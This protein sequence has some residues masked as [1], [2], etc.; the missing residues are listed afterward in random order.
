MSGHCCQVEMGCEEIPNPCTCHCPPCAAA[1]MRD[2]PMTEREVWVRWE[3]E[4]I[5]EC[6]LR[7]SNEGAWTEYVPVSDLLALEAELTLERSKP[8][9]GFSEEEPKK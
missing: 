2:E 5:A 3:G 4:F 1:R 6:A 8:K 9:D 7:P